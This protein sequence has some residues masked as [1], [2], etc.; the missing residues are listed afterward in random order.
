MNAEHSEQIFADYLTTH[1]MCYQREYPVNGANVDFCIE[2]ANSRVLCD[3]KEVRESKE[4]RIAEIDAH[5]HIRGDIRK[6]RAKFGKNRPSVPVFLVT[7]NF[8]SNFFTGLTIARALLGDIGINFDRLTST[9]TSPLHHLPRGNAALTE[10]SNRSISAVLVFDCATR[11]QHYLFINP[12]ADKPIPEDFF[13]TSVRRVKLRRDMTQ[14]ELLQ[15]SNF[16]FWP[17]T[18]GS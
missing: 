1:G 3:V 10:A 12:F 17:S 8:S 4:E 13:P 14:E 15:L 7:M 6:L 16:M 5:Y 11:C 2:M 18:P 9:V